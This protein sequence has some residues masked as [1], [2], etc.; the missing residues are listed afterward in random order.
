MT[1]IQTLRKIKEETQAEDFFSLSIIHLVHLL[2]NDIFCIQSNETLGAFS[3]Q[4]HEYT[5]VQYDYLLTQNFTF[6]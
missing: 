3:I 1:S 5:N 6:T 4:I 2:N